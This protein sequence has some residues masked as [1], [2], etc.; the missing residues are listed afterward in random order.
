MFIKILIKCEHSICASAEVLWFADRGTP[1]VLRAFLLAGD[2]APLLSLQTGRDSEQRTE[3]EPSAGVS[4]RV[5]PTLK[6]LCP[7]SSSNL[8]LL[9]DPPPLPPQSCLSSAKSRRPLQWRCSSS[10]QTSGRTATRRRWTWE[11]EVRLVGKLG[12]HSRRLARQAV[13]L[14]C[15][16]PPTYFGSVACSMLTNISAA[17][18]PWPSIQANGDASI[19]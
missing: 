1:P 3:G 4:R 17:A 13:Q 10:L 5:C 11:S 7:V 18:T 12:R 14:P 16:I 19:M 6:H 8:L 9:P 15:I 2:W